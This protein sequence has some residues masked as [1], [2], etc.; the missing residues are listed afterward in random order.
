MISFPI[1]NIKSTLQY[2]QCCF[3]YFYVSIHE[4]HRVKNRLP[5]IVWI[6]FIKCQSPPQ[7]KKYILMIMEVHRSI[8][9]FYLCVSRTK[10]N[11]FGRE[12]D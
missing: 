5:Q 10:Q 2:L 8:A 4:Q 9:F 7:S 3:R 1:A 11:G 12:E 6:C